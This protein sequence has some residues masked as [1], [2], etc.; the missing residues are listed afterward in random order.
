MYGPLCMNVDVLR[1]R[2]A[3]PLLNKGDVLVVHNV[4]AYNV[5]QSMQFISYRPAVVLLDKNSHAKIIRGAD[6]F[7][8]VTCKEH[9]EE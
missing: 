8:Y 4:G 3:L 1:E 6:D 7:E 2:V 9:Y 5:T